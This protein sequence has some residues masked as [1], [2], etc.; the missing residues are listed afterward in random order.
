M[1]DQYGNITAPEGQV[2]VCTAC[3][4]MSQDK[5]GD[6]AITPGWDESCML[7]AVL[8]HSDSIEY[9]PTGRVIAVKA[10]EEEE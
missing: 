6:Q 7:H 8:C 4:K 1:S 9:G 5:Y 3:G 2:F 10:V